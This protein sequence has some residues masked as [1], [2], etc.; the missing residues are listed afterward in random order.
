MGG[1][2]GAG[3]SGQ[4]GPNPVFNS[5]PVSCIRAVMWIDRSRKDLTSPVNR[6]KPVFR[7]HFYP[8]DTSLCKLGGGGE[9]FVEGYIEVTVSLS[10]SWVRVE[11]KR[12]SDEA[13]WE[14]RVEVKSDCASEFLMHYKH[15]Q[16]SK[17]FSPPTFFL[18]SFHF[19]VPYASSPPTHGLL[20]PAHQ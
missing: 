10:K 13:R 20:L 1:K 17:G 4:R 16:I 8:F 7:L 15:S 6:Q 9:P 18:L 12:A 11:Q 19:L 14:L 2:G 3:Q 5:I